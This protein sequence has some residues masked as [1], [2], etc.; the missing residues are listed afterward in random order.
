RGRG[1]RCRRVD[2]CI[3]LL[4]G[5]RSRY[6]PQPTFLYVPELPAIEFFERAEFPWLHA[7][8]EAT[9]DIRAELARVLASDQAGLQPD[10]AYGEGVPLDQIGRASCRERV[11]V[12]GGAGRV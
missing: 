12:W 10:V 5:K 6:A 7:I 4:T 1:S 2:R 3:D 11:W 9:E 8:E